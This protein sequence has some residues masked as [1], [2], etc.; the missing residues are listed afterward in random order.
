VEG[1]AGDL[2]VLAAK[3]RAFRIIL[4]EE[5]PHLEESADLLDELEL[6][7]DAL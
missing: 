5:R 1:A 3:K 6:E 7:I 2:D 4:A